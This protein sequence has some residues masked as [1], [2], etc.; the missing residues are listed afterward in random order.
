M[1]QYCIQQSCFKY[2][3]IINVSLYAKFMAQRNIDNKRN[4]YRCG[5][6]LVSR[7]D[8]NYDLISIRWFMD[9]HINSDN[10]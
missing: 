6:Q 8:N 10:V 4:I 9:F 3:F 1:I 7:V 2:V 5:K